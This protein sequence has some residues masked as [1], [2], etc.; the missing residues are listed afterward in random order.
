MAD[1]IRKSTNRFTKGLVMDFSPENTKNELLTHALNATLLTFNGNELS[2]QNDMGNGRVETAFLPEGY[3]PV[4]TCEYGGII[5]IVSY[6]PLEDKSQIGCFPSPE[7]NISNEELGKPDALISKSYFQEIDKDSGE[8]TGNILHNTQYVLLKNDKL[9]PGDKFIVCA[10]K[11][12]YNEK[13]ADLWVDKDDKYYPD[14]SKNPK[15]FELVSNPIVALNVVSIEDSGKIV[16][17]NNDIKQYEESNSYNLDGSDY[18]DTYKYHILGRMIPGTNQLAK[19]DLDNYRNILSSGYSVF[20]SKTSGKLAILAELIMI[21]SYSVTH[22]VKPRLNNGNIVDGAFDVIIHTEISPEI[23]IENYNT[24]PKLQYFYLQNSQ[25][26]LQTW[27]NT[28]AKTVNR[29]LFKVDK[30]NKVTKEYNNDF[31]NTPMNTIYTAMDP[32]VEAIINPKEENRTSPTLGSLGQ[33]NFPKPYTYHGRML[34]YNGDL[35]GDAANHVYTKFTEGKYHRIDYSQISSN[36][37]Y[38]NKDVQAKFYYYNTEGQIHIEY[39]EGTLDE[40]YTYYIRKSADIFHDAERKI[41]YQGDD[42]YELLTHELAATED[43][44]KDTS[45]EKF[46][47]QK[48]H[49]YRKATQDDIDGGKELY[50]KGEDGQTY[51]ELKGPPLD[52]VDYYVLE[53][54]ENLVSI[55]FEI[56][57]DTIQGEVYYYPAEKVFEPATAVSRAKYYDFNTYPYESEPPYGCPITLYRREEKWEYIAVTYEEAEEYLKENQKLFY[58]TDYILIKEIDK[59]RESNQLFIVVPMDTFVAYENFEPN[60]IYNYIEGKNKPSGE[61]PKDDPI[62]LYTLA[63]FIPEN[64]DPNATEEENKNKL[65]YN[66]VTLASIKLPSVVYNNGLDLPFKYDYTIVPCMNY[67]RLDHLAVSNTVDFSKLHAFNQSTFNTW[68]YYIQDNQLKL[69]FGAEVYDTYETTKVDGLILE[70]YDCWGFAGS[71]EIV[72]KKAYSGIFTKIIPLNSLK[73]INKKKILANDYSEVYRH[74]INIVEKFDDEGKSLGFFYNDKKLSNGQNQNS[75]WGD[76]SETDSDCGTL[77]SNVLYGVKAYLRRTTDSGKEFIH[78]KNFFLYTL[79]IYNDY[80]YTTDDFN[81]LEEPQL[82]LMLTYKIK[83]SSNRVPYTQDSEE[84]GIKNGYTPKDKAMIDDYLAG[85]SDQSSIDIIRYYK[86]KGTS[87]VYLEVGLRKEYEALNL[88]YDPNINK[89]FTCDLKLISDESEDQTFSVNSGIEGLTGISQILNYNNGEITIQKE[90]DSINNLGFNTGNTKKIVLGELYNAN[91]IHHEGTQPIQINYEFI[92]GYTANI[93]DI[94]STQVQATTICALFHQNPNGEYNYEDFGVYEQITTDSAGNEV[95]Q[96]LSNAIFYNEG[97]KEKEIFGLCRQTQTTGTMKDQL[98]SYASVETDA[99][100]I[101][102]QGKL[103]SGEPLKQLVG[104]LGKLTFCQPHAHGF[105]E[106]NGVNVHEGPGSNQ[107]GIPPEFSKTIDDMDSSEKSYGISARDYL[108]KKPKYNLSVNT[109]NAINYNSEFISTMHYKEISGQVFMVNTND[110]ESD[111][112]GWYGPVKM[113]EFVGMTGDELATFNQKMLE[114]MKHVYAYNPDYDSLTVNVGNI[115]LQNYNPYF[116][117]NLFSYNANLEFK[118]QTLNDFIYFGPIKFSNYLL[119]LKKYS[120]SSDGTFIEVQSK[121]QFLPQVQLIPGYDYCGLNNSYYLI[122]SL[123]YNTPVPRDLEAELEF[124]ASDNIVIKHTDG[125]NTFMKGTP[126]KKVLYGYN[127]KFDKMIQLDVSNYTIDVDGKLTVKDDGQRDFAQGSIEIDETSGPSIYDHGVYTFDYKFLNADNEE[128]TINLEAGIN[129]YSNNGYLIPLANGKNE[130]DFIDVKYGGVYGIEQS[131][132]SYYKSGQLIITPNINVTSSNNKKDYTY[133]V[134]INSIELLINA[135][136]VSD[137]LSM[138]GGDTPL[139]NQS[140]DALAKL[141]KYENTTLVNNQGGNITVNASNYRVNQD[142]FNNYITFSNFYT[143]SLQSKDFNNSRSLNLDYSWNI[144]SNE[145]QDPYNPGNY[146]KYNGYYFNMLFDIKIKKI[147]FT[148][149]QISK[150]ESSTDQFIKTTRTIKYSKTESNKYQIIDDY[151]NARLRGSSIT[152]NDL[153][154]EPNQDGHR[155]FMR[156]NLWNYDSNLRG[157]LYYRG[158]DIHDSTTR[159]TWHYK[160]KYYNNIFLFTG[161]CFTPDTLN[162]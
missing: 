81:T 114:T 156:N 23:T 162:K 32:A 75:G 41:E 29:T 53:I 139:Q 33:F 77:Y 69:T 153:I 57:Y 46:Q 44:I 127:E 54:E 89:Y 70:F 48:I 25:G 129:I 52:G 24:V 4:G 107:Y 145:S 40:Q 132:D 68:K 26:Y 71:I 17:L 74:N 80:Y 144:Y 147:N 99:Q 141:V 120:V 21:D 87:D 83:D 111:D 39:E 148:V 13:L 151:K 150:L 31:Y 91:F 18:S 161:P 86:Y 27:N 104:H 105:S 121:T 76:I 125:S 152:L 95:R 118:E 22:E 16:Y 5:Y 93:S 106:T 43:Q 3:M 117:S 126:N 11:T 55:G 35:V 110:D 159:A 78:K 149:E 133:K 72:D 36:L 155:L 20:K 64:I 28:F 158:L 123:T 73:A 100:E 50:Y 131:T 45:I 42:L 34:P 115:S 136:M 138:H 37:D 79:P 14:D 92:V 157:K 65:K 146:W 88:S 109:K 130:S 56:D 140:Y 30:N 9:N 1:V 101:K 134:T 60:E 7:R 12:I 6:N 137:D 103:N 63:D 84:K 112:S 2:L 143:G 61:Y 154:Y 124:S 38:F 160:T 15:D 96:L 51:I 108:Y 116:T 119:Q 66:P 97:T 94:R 49:T 58:S 135:I 128:T 8:I 10:E 62:S 19:K 47:Y 67:G 85:F 82:D 102:T 59:Y 113:R 142:Q 122:S 90:G 98:S